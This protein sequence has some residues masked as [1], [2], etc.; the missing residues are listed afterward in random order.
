[1]RTVKSIIEEICGAQAEDKTYTADDITMAVVCGIEEGLQ[2]YAWW[3]DGVQYVGTW[4]IPL[5][6]ALDDLHREAARWL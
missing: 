4:G 6:K 3:K 2:R 1:M 5:A